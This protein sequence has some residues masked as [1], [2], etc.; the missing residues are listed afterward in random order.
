MNVS[1]GTRVPANTRSPLC[2]S[3]SR[4]TM[5]PMSMSD[6][7]RVSCI[8]LPSQFVIQPRYGAVPARSRP[9]T[10]SPSGVRV[11]SRGAD[12]KV[13]PYSGAVPLGE[14]RRRTL[15]R[16]YRVLGRAVCDEHRTSL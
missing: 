8:G 5:V 15:V 3:G 6:A 9:D 13:N 4:D 10:V 7:A 2:T 12:E 14:F 11:A 1:T 16:H